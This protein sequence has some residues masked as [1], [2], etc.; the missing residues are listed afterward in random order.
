MQL[1]PG[2]LYDAVCRLDLVP[3]PPR[4]VLTPPFGDGSMP[5]F[6]ADCAFM[7]MALSRKLCDAVAVGICR[8]VLHGDENFEHV[9]GVE[10]TSE[11]V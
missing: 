7:P 4:Y 8:A 9:G 10:C 11:V 5:R 1:P 6:L 3:V 2:F